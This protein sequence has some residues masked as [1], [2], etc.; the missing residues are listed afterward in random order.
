MLDLRLQFDL[1]DVEKELYRREASVSRGTGGLEL[2]ILNVEQDGGMLLSWTGDDGCTKIGKFEPRTKRTKLLYAFDRCVCISSCSLNS[3]ETLLAVSLSQN[4]RDDQ[5]P[6]PISKCVTLLME[7][8]PIHNTKVLKAV[9]CRVKVQFLHAVTEHRTVHESHLL[10]LTGDGYVDLLHVPL[11]RQQGDRVVMLNPERLSRTAEQLV[12]D[13]SCFQWDQ[14]SQRLFYIKLQDGSMLLHCVQF[15]PDRRCETVLQLPLKLPENAFPEVQFVNLG[16]DHFHTSVRERVRVEVFTQR[17]GSLY[18]CCSRL[19]DDG[20]E[21]AYT[22]ILLHK[23]VSKTFRVTLGSEQEACQHPLFFTIG[24]YLVAHLSGC[25]LH[26]INSRQPELSC[27]S[28]FLSG[29]DAGS[30]LQSG[31]FT[32]LHSESGSALLDWTRGQMYQVEFSPAPLLTILH[33][34]TPARQPR[35]WA[36][37]QRLAALH[38]LLLQMGSDPAVELQII[39]WLCDCMTRIHSFNP[40]QEVLMASLFRM[41]CHQTLGLDPV[42]PFSSLQQLQEVAPSLLDVPGAICSTETQLRAVCTVK[43]GGVQGFWSELQWNIERSK[44]L[45]ALQNSRYQTTTIRDDW[46][47]LQRGATPSAVRNLFLEDAQKVLNAMDSCLDKRLVPLLQEDDHLQRALIGLTVNKLR[48]HLRRFV[49]RLGKKKIDAIAIDYVAKLLELIRHML[50]SVWLRYKLDPHVLSL[51]ASVGPAESAVFHFMFRTLEA[52]LGLCLPLPLGFNSL[53][54]VLA[55]R[56][57]PRHTFLQY[58]DHRCLQLTESFVC[59]LMTELD[60]SDDNEK[61]KFSV[62]SRLTQPLQQ[63][64]FHMWDH[65]ISSA[66]ISRAY[67]GTLLEQRHTHKGFGSN[68]E[69]SSLGTDFLPLTFLT[70]IL[71]DVEGAALQQVQQQENIDSHFVEETALKQTL[72]SLGLQRK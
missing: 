30:G 12:E 25:F 52:T 70:G 17:E 24:S 28:L 55:L 61:L 51:K 72:V 19:P 26:C 23:D 42:L 22:V 54:S 36:D 3:E 9:D 37:S 10:V 39:D 53:L 59:R 40:F 66:S 2:R 7:I 46:N 21:V 58:L 60:N 50:E 68:R 15:Y 18:V 57:L 45:R 31:C 1:T 32:V 67:V 11:T 69:R 44:H 27:H 4:H 64:L 34:A 56:C 38:I 8:R 65:P 16:F 33:S 35:T 47:K 29:D 13:A 5:R 43:T 14:N 48:E 63:K 6:K 62:L 71:S 41:C 49:P 20:Q